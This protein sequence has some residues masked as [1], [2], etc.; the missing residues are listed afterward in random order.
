MTCFYIPDVRLPYGRISRSR[1]DW[2]PDPQNVRIY[3]SECG[4]RGIRLQ[5]RKSD[6]FEKADIIKPMKENSLFTMLTSIVDGKVDGLPTRPQ[7]KLK[8]KVSTVLC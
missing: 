4:E 3:A 6:L 7:L 8:F 5:S 1:P 2:C